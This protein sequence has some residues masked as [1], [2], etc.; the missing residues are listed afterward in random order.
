MDSKWPLNTRRARVS[1]SVRTAGSV[2]GLAAVTALQPWSNAVAGSLVTDPDFIDDQ[3]E[4]YIVRPCFTAGVTL[5][6]EGWTLGEIT[7]FNNEI[8]NTFFP[9]GGFNNSDAYASTSN[10]GSVGAIDNTSGSLAQQQADSI[11]DRLDELKDEDDADSGWGFLVS[12]QKGETERASTNN[13]VGFESDLDGV[14]VGF[15]YRYNDR[16]VAGIAAG[17]TSDSADYDGDAGFIDTDSNSLTLYT[18][19]VLNANSYID[20]YLGFATLDYENERDITVT[21]DPGLPP[22][23]GLNGTVSS[24]FDGD[25][26]LLGVSYG[27]DWYRGNHSYGLSAALDMIRTTIDDHDEDG[28]T[29]L[30]LTYDEQ[31]TESTMITLGANWSYTVDMGWGALVP[32]VGISAVLETEDDAEV[33]EVR[34]LNMPSVVPF[35]ELESDE[36]DTE[37]VISSLGLIVAMNSGTQYFVTYEQVSSHDFLDN[38]SISAGL[39][40]EF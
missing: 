23:A 25:Q 13:E 32:N 28:T 6:A 15:D 20:A 7:R 1:R 8:C 26:T 38:W 37:Y 18:T 21:G 35:L 14:V 19:Y 16:L 2:V 40:T 22:I 29:N 3:F 4:T 10:I 34:L 9:A 39:L 27:Y 31:T 33:S 12:A 5:L 11:K 36:P 24:S 17:V 30:E